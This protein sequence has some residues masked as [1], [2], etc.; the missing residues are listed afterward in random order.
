M[1]S[2][3]RSMRHKVSLN[4]I[5]NRQNLMI[6]RE[7]SEEQIVPKQAIMMCSK[8]LDINDR[9]LYKLI[10]FLGV[11]CRVLR[12]SDLPLNDELFLK[13]I[14]DENP[15]LVMSCNTLINILSNHNH[16]D[17]IRSLLFS[18][19]AYLLIYNLSATDLESSVIKYLTNGIIISLTH[20]VNSNYNYNVSNNCV[21]VCM[22]FSGLSFGP[23]NK[24]CDFT[25]DKKTDSE[26]IVTLISIDDRPFFLKMKEDKCDL[27]LTANNRVVDI[28]KKLSEVFNPTDY[29]SQ[30]VPFIMFIRYAFRDSCWHIARNHASFIIDDPLIKEK[31]GFLDYRQL[32]E[33][34]GQDKFF[35][36][37]AFIPY[38]YRR[39]DQRVAK[40]LAE[41]RNKFAISV[42]GCDH[43]RGEFGITDYTTLNGR[44]RLATARMM[45][46]EKNTKLKFDKVMV[47]PQGIFSRE[48][49]RM[50]K[51]NN[52]LSAVN[53][54]PMPVDAKGYIKFSN[55]LEPCIMS[56]GSFPL[57]MRRYP[58]GILDFAFDIFL[59]KPLLIVVHHDYF[60]KGYDK[61][62]HFVRKI[63]ALKGDIHWDGLGNIIKY[64]YLQRNGSDGNTYIKVYANYTV[65]RNTSNGIKSCFITKVEKDGSAIEKIMI[66][67]KRIPFEIE[68]EVLN[69]FVEIEP[70]GSV[71]V[72]IVYK[73]EYGYTDEMKRLILRSRV[74]LRRHVTEIRDNY[75]SKNEFV[76]KV[77]DKGING[78]RKV[79]GL[80]LK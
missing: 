29:F 20:L 55:F 32:L 15:C 43:T 7:K 9:N 76:S 1:N 40:L 42:H 47:F 51:C 16:K 19:I 46:H 65:I 63:N 39:S 18:K 45:A 73:N 34:I 44:I 66:N 58:E 70:G 27:F 30:I 24:S 21:D 62:I 71:E 17:H 49:M 36:T 54:D 23:V 60:R 26:N 31:Y 11:S 56:Y 53:S 57:F 61:L 14:K 13:Q 41:N 35:A 2:E 5:M 12:L 25:F 67:G 33:V 52:Y 22:Q 68:N 50:L 64:T 78:I 74:F 8:E 69:L 72:E 59:G 6:N 3:T 4:Y 77:A 10:E 79:K 28:D 80:L 38:N 37:I 75:V 48:S